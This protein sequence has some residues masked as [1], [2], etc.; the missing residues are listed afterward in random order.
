MS[1]YTMTMQT[2][3]ESY[4]GLS[5][6][7]EFDQI[8]SVISQSR[9]K[10]FNFTF[11]IFQ[12]S[13]RSQLEDKIIKYFWLREIGTETVGE[14]KL[15]LSNKLNRIM[16]Y[17]NQ[18]YNS[19]LLDFDP[20]L[21]VKYTRDANRNVNLTG[22]ESENGNSNTTITGTSKSDSNQT[23]TIDGTTNEDSTTDATN[24]TTNSG[25]AVESDTPQGLIQDVLDKKYASRVNQTDSTS[26]D[27]GSTTYVSKSDSNQSET[28]IGTI[29]ANTSQT[30]VGKTDRNNQRTSKTVDDL[31]ETISGKEGTQTYSSMLIEFRETFLNID[32][33]IL[34]ELEELF[35]GL[36]G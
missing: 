35:F 19:A 26:D 6:H 24:T 32:S 21:N 1:L 30:N 15:N 20:L 2:L 14:F 36:W 31:L 13:Y 25:N 28:D 23:R 27:N 17:Y 11:P 18:L 22:N 5:D 10:V 3:C 8:D 33:M 4:A 7:V 12:E 16:P 29:N 34:D 9:G